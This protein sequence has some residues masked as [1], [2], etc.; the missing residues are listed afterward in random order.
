VNERERNLLEKIKHYKKENSQLI[1][2][3]KESENMIADKIM[4][5][6]KETDQIL[7]I[8]NKLWPLM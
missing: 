6:K 7:S 4:K 3:L 5:S 8:L 1:L 2:L